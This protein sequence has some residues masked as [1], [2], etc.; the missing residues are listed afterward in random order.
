M[1]VRVKSRPIPGI[2]QLDEFWKEYRS[3]EESRTPQQTE[4]DHEDKEPQGDLC[5]Q[6]VEWLK[7]AGFDELVK[8]YRD[9]KEI[10]PEDLD[11]K[12]ITS[13]LTRKQAEAVK[14]RI[15]TLN[16][17]TKKKLG[18]SV[19]ATP[20]H[21]SKHADV[22]TI[23]PVQTKGLPSNTSLG[24]ETET[25]SDTQ[26]D[27]SSN[28]IYAT[29]S[30]TPV[31]NARQNASTSG[32]WSHVGN[33]IPALPRP[34]LPR[35]AVSEG[36]NLVKPGIASDQSC[37]YG[38]AGKYSSLG[39]D[40]N[41]EHQ[42]RENRDKAGR[43][44]HP[45]AERRGSEEIKVH[46]GV[47]QGKLR[48]GS[49]FYVTG[50]SKQ[51]MFNAAEKTKESVVDDVEDSRLNIKD[52]SVSTPSTPE[53][54]QDTI[55]E[56][57]IDV[58]DVNLSPKINGQAN[59]R[60]D[61]F[62]LPQFPKLLNFTLMKDELGVTQISDFSK[63]DMEKVR[64][65]A[66]IELTALF[67]SHSLPFHRRKPIKK[68]VKE[69]GIFGVPLQYMLQHDRS[70]GYHTRIPIFLKEVIC[71]LDRYGLK[72]EG[73]LRVS[74]STTRIKALKEE[75]EET[76]NEGHFNWEGQR[77][78]DIV[79]LL[80]TFLRELPFP[81]LTH[82]YQP[83][84]ASVESIPDR[85]QQLQALNLLILLLPS[86]HRDCLRILL[87]FLKQVTLHE[88]YNKMSPNNVAMIMAPNLFL[89]KSQNDLQEIRMA[90]GTVNIVRMLIKYQNILWTIPGFMV[91]QV[92]YLYEAEGTKKI[93]DTKAVRK[94]IS[95]KGKE[96]SSNSPQKKHSI[97]DAIPADVLEADLAN[98]IIRVKAPMLNKFAM[99]IQLVNGMTAGDVVD[100]FKRRP[101]GSSTVHSRRQDLSHEYRNCVNPQGENKFA[102]D[103]HYLYEVGGNIGERRLDHDT[104][105]KAL[106][107][108]NPSAE[109]IIKP[110]QD[111]NED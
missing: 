49:V 11:V 26:T 42:T 58:P 57:A 21:P 62:K 99:V 102:Q 71:Y 79:S 6:E 84:F 63:Q 45:H 89:F 40:I 55:H 46:S 52:L 90:Q 64:S 30:Q 4:E 111:N 3:I 73:I 68:K 33:N 107:K 97:T 75:I 80:K 60:K 70:R 96:A 85:K 69:T 65:L 2:D 12:D 47:Q 83:T 91:M 86:V 18:I 93:K 13:S 16:D 110:L 94:L 56:N 20:L 8:K 17:N 59:P 35:R 38:I 23:F 48:H 50:L 108:V 9:S 32:S 41:G 61:R 81:L 14:R 51:E 100:K 67:D 78:H 104:N 36:V 53:T 5:E 39:D 28:V 34:L 101:E 76:F 54:E 87:S 66:L 43:P 29:A 7:E 82:E 22:R 19:N 10:D 98:N 105:M 37:N 109:W 15:N 27:S 24:S 1:A 95:K 44:F 88:E 74:G 31:P 92:R 103:N 25:T 106:Y 72:E 77:P